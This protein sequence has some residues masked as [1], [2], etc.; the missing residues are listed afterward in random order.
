MTNNRKCKICECKI[1]AKVERLSNAKHDIKQ[2]TT[3]DEG[4]LFEYDENKR[5]AW[6]CNKCWKKVLKL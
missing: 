4:V 6:F 3:S 2:M 5:G 1:S